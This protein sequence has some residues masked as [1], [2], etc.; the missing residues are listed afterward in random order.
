M[1]NIKT[2]KHIKINTITMTKL[3]TGDEQLVL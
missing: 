1:V 3:K 2:S